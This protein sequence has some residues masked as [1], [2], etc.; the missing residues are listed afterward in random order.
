[1]TNRPRVGEILLAA[2]IIDEMQLQ[3][4]LGEQKQW[5]RRL[6]VTL[7][8]LGMVEEGHLIRALAKQLDLP[9][10][11][12]AGK[13]I[14]DDVIALVPSRVASKHGVIPLFKKGDG[15]SGQLFLGM[16]DPSNLEVLDDLSFRTGMEIHPVMIGPTELGEAIDRYYHGRTG[17]AP[18]SDPFHGNAGDTMD[19]AAL[20]IVTDDS[21]QPGTRPAEPS[22]ED[23]VA[24]A[25][26]REAPR[27]NATVPAAKP[28]SPVAPQAATKP[29]PPVAPPA[30]A[31]PA[32][33]A[34]T[35]TA[36][37]A[38]AL[39]Q[40]SAPDAA[41]PIVEAA[42]APRVEAP[43]P[44]APEQPPA[45]TLPPGLVDDVARALEDT[46]RTRFVAK[47]IATLLVEKGVLG[48]DELQAQIALH[49]ADAEIDDD[50][51]DFEP[52]ED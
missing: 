6:G 28:T 3:S 49:R 7:I 8:K 22:I 16:E 11:S 41:A 52:L 45:P 42:P 30:A 10:A 5:G 33:S 29:I 13:R 50:G 9:V 32:P 24:K 46:A 47:A 35:P 18:R 12:L 31:P 2:G 48:L 4:A 26:R 38:P 43:Q 1:M 19:P 34:V 21:A 14:P 20:R 36:T 23:E 44:S 37:P 39:A 15:P 25:A 40:P 51:A 17:G 27:P